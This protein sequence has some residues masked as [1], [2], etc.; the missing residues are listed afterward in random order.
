MHGAG[1]PRGEDH[2]AKDA[3]V[4]VVGAGKKDAKRCCV[5]A[6]TEGRKPQGQPHVA[7]GAFG[8]LKN[9]R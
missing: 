8:S 2:A 1:P 5:T 6:L 3:Y 7:R 9:Q 4:G